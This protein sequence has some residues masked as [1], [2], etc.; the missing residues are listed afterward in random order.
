MSYDQNAKEVKASL[1]QKKT[2]VFIQPEIVIPP[3][4]REK[5]TNIKKKQLR[6]AQK[7]THTKF[8]SPTDVKETK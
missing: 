1:T 7:L 2:T 6:L 8:R 5:Q 4:K 3:K